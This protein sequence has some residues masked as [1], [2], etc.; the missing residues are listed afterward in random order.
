V[1]FAPAAGVGDISFFMQTVFAGVGDAGSCAAPPA[2]NQTCTPPGSAVTFL[3]V[4]GN[5]SSATITMQGF[6][7]HASD[8]PGFAAASPM[9]YI[10]TAQF[11][12]PF[13]SVLADFAA[14]GSLTSTYSMTATTSFTPTNVPEPSSLLLL[15]SGL[16][17]L[18]AVMRRKARKL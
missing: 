3:N 7:R 8:A 6:A 18:A 10:F 1:T 12:Q 17:G 4:S 13:Q 15:G 11:N 16:T 5:N 9:Q 2:T 14:S